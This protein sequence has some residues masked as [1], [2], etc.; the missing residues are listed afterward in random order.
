M[1]DKV[2]VPFDDAVG[3]LVAYAGYSPTNGSITYPKTFD[4]RLELFNFPRAENMGVVMDGL[5]VVTDLL[6]V[7]RLYEFGVYRVVALTTET[8]YPPQCAR[9][10][11][12]VGTGARS[13]LFRGHGVRRQPRAFPTTFT[14]GSTVTT[15]GARTSSSRRWH[16]VWGSRRPTHVRI[17]TVRFSLYA[18]GCPT[19]P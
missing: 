11:R 17:A 7:L 2:V 19:P 10:E 12:L 16:S 18:I 13:I 14:S 15:K 9:V 8:L 4:Q 6:N 1:H 5:V 3:R